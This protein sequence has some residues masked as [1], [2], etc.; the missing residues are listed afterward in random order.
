MEAKDFRSVAESFVAF[1]DES[2]EGPRD[3]LVRE[4]ERRIAE[5]YVAA[6]SLP[7]PGE[8]RSTQPTSSMR[9]DEAA[10]LMRR[11]SRQL[12]DYDFYNLVFDPYD[13]VDS[14]PVTG[15]LADDVTD[16]YRD[17]KN[18]LVAYDAGETEDA[19]WEWRFEFDSH[20]GRHAA[21]ALYA[22]HVLTIDRLGGHF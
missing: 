5:L 8:L 6:L 3:P 22:I 7:Q 10:S 21:N 13:F 20:W 12:G 1:V 18:G 4:L 2:A 11:L 16:I 9:H 17:L 19:V 15:S 14:T